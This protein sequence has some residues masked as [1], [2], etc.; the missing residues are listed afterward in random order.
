VDRN[1]AVS[2]KLFQ[3]TE[4]MTWKYLDAYDNNIKTMGKQFVDQ[5]LTELDN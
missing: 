1:N 3:S 5:L 2:G 4:K